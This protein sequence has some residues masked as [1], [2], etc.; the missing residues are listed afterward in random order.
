MTDPALF[1]AGGK[2]GSDWLPNPAYKLD[3]RDIH[4]DYQ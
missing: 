1:G 2:M 3:H 4:A